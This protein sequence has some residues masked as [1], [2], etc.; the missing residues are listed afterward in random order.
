MSN[1]VPQKGQLFYVRLRP[2]QRQVIVDGGPLGQATVQKITSHDN[3]YREEIF[4]C[5]GRDDT[6]V[7]GK[8]LTQSYSSRLALLEIERCEFRPVGPDVAAAM[9]FT[10]EDSTI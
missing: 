10:M 7:V 8:N 2:V 1:F 4:R 9:G 6:H 5:R 3:S